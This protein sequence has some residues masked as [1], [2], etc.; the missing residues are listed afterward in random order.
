MAHSKSAKKRV[1]IA[2]RNRLRNKAVM[3]KVKTA[4]K[5]FENS[6]ESENKEEAKENLVNAQKQ[7]D[8]AVTKNIFHKNKAARKKSQLANKFN[9]KFNN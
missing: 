4:L 9:A 1:V 7:C 3:T 2:E 5:K 6:L 8:R